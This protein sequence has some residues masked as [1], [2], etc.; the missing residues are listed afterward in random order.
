M[1][2][3]VKMAFVATAL[4]V[5][6][7]VFVVLSTPTRQVNKIHELEG[8]TRVRLLKVA[9]GK[10][11][12][13]D[14]TLFPLGRKIFSKRW[15]D[16]LGMVET[17]KTQRSSASL[18]IWL[19]T[20]G[21]P[22]KDYSPI[23]VDEHGMEARTVV[24]SIGYQRND[25]S[26]IRLYFANAFQRGSTNVTLR[27]CRRNTRDALAQISFS[28]PGFVGGTNWLA[29]PFPVRATSGDL[30]FSLT[31]LVVGVGH[32]DGRKADAGEEAYALAQFEVR[33][34]GML[35]GN[36]KP[37]QFGIRDAAGNHVLPGISHLTK[38]GG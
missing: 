13:L 6:L 36:W 5:G 32:L 12:T 11:H 15:Q 38:G 31:N 4:F 19:E 28:N 35:V 24:Y 27:F 25:G 21:D 1:S 7:I 8:G 33:D 2:Q 14:E 26:K 10:G 37:T 9:F 16:R 17:L 34:K 18:G 30:E 20:W 29:K 3:K 22:I 23:L